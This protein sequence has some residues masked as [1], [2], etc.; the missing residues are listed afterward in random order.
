MRPGLGAPLQLLRAPAMVHGFARMLA[1]SPAAR[2]QVE[3][4]CSAWAE[5]IGRQRPQSK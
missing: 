4:A 1:A 5:L 2:Q 3:L